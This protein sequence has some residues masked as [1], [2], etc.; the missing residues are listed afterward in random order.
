[1]GTIV[2]F[3]LKNTKKPTGLFPDSILRRNRVWKKHCTT[4]FSLPV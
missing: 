4:A 3:P 1:M 2:P